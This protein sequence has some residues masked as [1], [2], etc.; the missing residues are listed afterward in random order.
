MAA[1][2][3]LAGAVIGAAGS[4]YTGMANSAAYKYQ[5]G[6]A[7]ANAQ[8]DQQNASYETALGEAKAQES[9]LKTAATIGATL[10]QQGASGLATGEGIGVNVRVSEAEIGEDQQ[11]VIR[12]TAAR[13]AYGYEV[14]KAQNIA[15]E[16]LYNSMSDTALISGGLNALSS[17]LG[18]GGSFAEKWMQAGSRGMNPWTAG[19]PFGG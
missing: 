4:L 12:N 9:G 6:V 14:E 11:A 19:N 1:P 3:V 2:L 15:Q 8:I 7:A 13:R 18:G 16:G 17:V 5:A 10:A